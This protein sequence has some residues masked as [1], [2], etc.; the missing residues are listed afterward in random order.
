VGLYYYGARYF[1]PQLGRFVSPDTIIPQQQG[2]QAW[3]RYAYVNNNPIKYNDPTGHWYC[4]D[5]YDPACAETIEEE[6]QFYELTHPLPSGMV[7]PDELP[8]GIHDPI[9]IEAWIWL[10]NSTT[11]RPWAEFIRDHGLQ[12]VIAE[13]G[14]G[15]VTVNCS[16]TQCTL[17]TELPIYM[18]TDS[19]SLHPHTLAAALAH[20]TYHYTRPFGNVRPSLF[21]EYYAYQRMHDIEVE[22][23]KTWEGATYVIG[24]LDFAGYDP[25]N[26]DSLVSWFY[27]NRLDVYINRVI[28][29]EYVYYPINLL[30]NFHRGR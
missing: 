2:S 21:E 16:G 28:A 26:Q 9:L 8:T 10:Y 25:W 6:Y 29:G 4:G 7:I 3:D 27:A 13:S 19:Y 12:V 1:D 22:L 20:E 30:I 5:Q 17:D 11:G 15:N 14:T 24:G 18:P 23:I